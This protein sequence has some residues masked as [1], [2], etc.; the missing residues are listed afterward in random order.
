MIYMGRLLS[1][2]NSK[3]P[4]NIFRHSWTREFIRARQE[5]KMEHVPCIICVWMNE[6]EGKQHNED[7]MEPIPG[8]IEV[9]LIN[10]SAIYSAYC[11]AYYEL[12]SFLIKL[13]EVYSETLAFDALL[14]W[15]H[16]I[17]SLIESSSWNRFNT[18][19]LPASFEICVLKSYSYYKRV[20]VWIWHFE[21]SN[22]YTPQPLDCWLV[23][24]TKTETDSKWWTSLIIIQVQPFQKRWLPPKHVN[25]CLSKHP[26]TYNH[27]LLPPSSDVVWI[28][29]YPSYESKTFWYQSA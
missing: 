24:W 19:N 4:Q 8:R 5:T 15:F 29:Y 11:K 20:P 28:I 10:H 9:H 13:L 18:H 1:C 2:E 25:E 7:I 22:H 6:E 12:L 23:K 17:E 27:R 16:Y 26:M 21:L 14:I 3:P